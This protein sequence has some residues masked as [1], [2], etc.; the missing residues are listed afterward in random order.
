ML[1]NLRER[2][3][4]DREAELRIAAEEHAKITALRLE[5]LVL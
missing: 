5:K 4:H 1:A 3:Q 2:L